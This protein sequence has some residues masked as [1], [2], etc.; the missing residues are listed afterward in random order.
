MSADGET[1][2]FTAAACGE[3]TGE[4]AGPGHNVPVEEVFARMGGARTVPI[5]EPSA[6]SQAAPYPGCSEE[7]CIKDVNEQANWSAASF[8]GAS[9]DGSKAFFTS[10]QRLTDGAGT[11]GN[12]YEYDSE[13]APAEGD[14]VDVSAGGVS[15]QE[16][17]VQG[18][19]AI[20]ADGSHVYFVAQGV[21]TSTANS[22][23]EVAQEG[24]NNLYVF[25]REPGSREV[26]PISSRSF[27]E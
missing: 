22:Q 20:S 11:E 17:R 16:P 14:L 23:G 7:P 26:R 1:L 19:V 27:P 8:A 24:A 10:N 13:N 21:L 4:N 18:V 2:Y 6:F 12:L 15:G 3:G 25:A 9:S 5:S